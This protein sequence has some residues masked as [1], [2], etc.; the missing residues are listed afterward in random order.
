M[1]PPE[2]ITVAEAAHRLG[3]SIEQ[4]RR[5]LREGKLKGQRIGQQWFIDPASLELRYRVSRDRP[6]QIRE[7]VAVMEAPRMAE[8]AKMTKEEIKALFRKIDERVEAIRRR[9]GGDLDTDLAEML[10][11]ERESH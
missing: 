9:I 10:R 3:R 4:V 5:Y 6:A 8:V 2:R 7:P 11:E 1:N